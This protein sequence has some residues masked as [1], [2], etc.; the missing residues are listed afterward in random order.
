MNYTQPMQYPGINKIKEDIEFYKN[1]FIQDTIL[2]F[3]NANLTHEEQE[4]L[5]RVLGDALNWYPNTTHEAVKRYTENHAPNAMLTETNKDVVVL[6]WHIEHPYFDNPIVSGL[7]NMLVFNIEE[8]RGTTLFLDTARIYDMLPEDWKQFLH[9]C[10]VNGYSYNHIDK[11]LC[12][13]AIGTHWLTGE[14]ILRFTIHRIE[15]GWHD[16]RFF[17]GRTPTEEENDKFIEIGNWIIYEINNNED[18]RLVHQWN[19]GDLIIPDLYK[20]AHAVKGGFNP[21]DRVFTG[22]WSYEK[23]IN[24]YPEINPV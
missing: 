14:S 4:E 18:L 7:W 9:K 5:Q 20:L 21:K 6:P 17:D 13:N 15:K 12:S 8:D 2:V 24:I 1:K 10:V 23:D 11:M 16:L 22:V 3:R 19:Q